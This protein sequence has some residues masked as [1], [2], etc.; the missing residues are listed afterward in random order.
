MKFL[1]LILVLLT[2]AGCN[3][4]GEAGFGALE[5][6]TGTSDIPCEISSNAPELNSVVVSAASGTK[7]VF[8]IVPSTSSCN[9]NFF[10]NGTKINTNSTNF[11]EIDSVTL[12]S[13]ANTVRVEASNSLGNDFYEWSVYKNAPPTCTRAVPTAAVTNMINTGTQSFTVNATK[14]EGET[15]E[16]TWLLDDSVQ[17][18]LVSTINAETASQALFS[19]TSALNGIRNVSVK[20]SV[21]AI[22][23]ELKLPCQE[24]LVVALLMIIQ[25]GRDGVLIAGS[26]LSRRSYFTSC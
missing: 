12:N 26:R 2:F 13:G 18:T 22:V 14:D 1:L 3:S 23:K 20:V 4:G 17:A 15:L 19:P 10:V 21:K 25:V 24:T 16:F 5:D 11:V 9:V 8:N 7:T 6:P